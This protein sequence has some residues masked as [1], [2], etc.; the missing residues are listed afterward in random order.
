MVFVYQPTKLALWR[1]DVYLKISTIPGVLRIQ[2]CTGPKVFCCMCVRG[3][4]VCVVMHIFYFKHLG[5]GRVQVEASLVYIVSSKLA[6]I[7]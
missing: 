5:G 7:T 1:N 3:L 4:C 2:F 6:R